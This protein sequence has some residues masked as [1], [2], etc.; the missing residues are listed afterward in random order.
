MSEQIEVMSSW[1]F[2]AKLEFLGKSRS[3]GMLNVIFPGDE[4]VRV[5]RSFSL[6]ILQLVCSRSLGAF[7]CETLGL[8][9]DHRA[10]QNDPL[11]ST[12]L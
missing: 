1:L 8:I 6:S 12:N 4:R 2:H 9:K 10:F 3:S 11:C 7:E 5:R